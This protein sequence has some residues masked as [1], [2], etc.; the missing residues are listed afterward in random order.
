MRW[1]LVVRLVIFFFFF[2]PYLRNT[3]N[4]KYK[5][6]VKEPGG[7]RSDSGE[8][9]TEKNKNKTNNIPREIRGEIAS[10]DKS[11]KL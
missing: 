11:M 2:D 4:M 1:H 8:K 10:I 7:K 5:I 6:K 3:T 9:N